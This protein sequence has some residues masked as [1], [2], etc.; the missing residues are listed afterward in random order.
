MRFILL[1]LGCFFVLSG[2]QA[3]TVINSDGYY[4]DIRLAGKVRVVDSFPDSIGEWQF[5][6]YGEDFTIQFV[7]SFP[8]ICI[9]FVHSFP[10]VE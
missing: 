1:I 10:G 2:V 6:S 9:R 5:V 7:D 4:K 8:D 3:A